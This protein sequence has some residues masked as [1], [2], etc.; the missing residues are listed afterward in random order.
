M[1]KK[2]QDYGN[3][4]VRCR[5]WTLDE[6]AGNQDVKDTIHGYPEEDFPRSIMLIGDT[7][8]GKT[9]LARIIAYSINCKNPIGPY[10]PCGGCNSCRIMDLSSHPSIKEVNATDNRTL[11]DMRNTI[12]ISKLAPRDKCQ[13]IILDELQG[14]TKAALS[15]LL[16]P[17]EEAYKK[18]VWILCASEVKKDLQPILGR[19]VEFH[20][21]YPSPG[22]LKDL[23]ASIGKREFDNETW[24]KLKSHLNDICFSCENQ[25]R[26]SIERMGQLAMRLRANPNLTKAEIYQF[27]R[28]IH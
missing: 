9:T 25:P 6:M 26:K 21:Q 10:Q 24:R 23:L 18:L 7:G 27:L 14:A 15:A 1:P 22:E 4:A 12:E 19:C 3:L 28:R 11:H 2:S 17:L 13:V 8:S 5:P 16:K 20:M